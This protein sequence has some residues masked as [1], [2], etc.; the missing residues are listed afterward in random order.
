MLEILDR[1]AVLMS[2]EDA[3]RNGFKYTRKS[4]LGRE[5]ERPLIEGL[6]AVNSADRQLGGE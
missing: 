5:L 1:G 6:L 3:T 4:I 2:K